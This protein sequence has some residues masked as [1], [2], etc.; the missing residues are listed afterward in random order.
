[1]D[2]VITLYNM[3]HYTLLL[4]LSFALNAQQQ[5]GKVVSVLDGDTVIV[6][7]NNIQT[8][9]RLAEID[10]PEKNQPFGKKAKQFTSDRV[11]SKTIFYEV[12]GKDKYGRS[13]AKIYY[14]PS[15]IYLNKELVEFGLA[16]HYKKYS[17]SEEL[18]RLE[19]NARNKKIGIWSEKDFIEPSAWRKGKKTGFKSGGASLKIHIPKRHYKRYKNST[20]IKV[21]KIR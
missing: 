12:T 4:F 5:T 9:L 18:S 10:C 21:I 14:G 13:I 6:L 7:D 20:F 11:F 3:R 1:M 2:A 15:K 17:D 16:W 19:V 8:K